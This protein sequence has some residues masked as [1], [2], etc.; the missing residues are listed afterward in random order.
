[1]SHDVCGAVWRRGMRVKKSGKKVKIKPKSRIRKPELPP[2]L[3]RRVGRLLVVYDGSNA[4][5]KRENGG[6]G[7]GLS[8]GCRDHLSHRDLVEI[9]ALKWNR[10]PIYEP[11]GGNLPLFFPLSFW[12]RARPCV[13]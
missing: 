13:S 11:L 5:N 10:G 2:E 3:G 8:E 9:T 1:M 7:G 12:W 6:A 4:R